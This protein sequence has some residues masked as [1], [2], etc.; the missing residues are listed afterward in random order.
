MK[1]EQRE[2]QTDKILTH[3]TLANVRH[4]SWNRAMLEL[5]LAIKQLKE[6][7]KKYEIKPVG[8][9]QTNGTLTK[10]EE[11][12]REMQQQAIAWITQVGFTPSKHYA[13]TILVEEIS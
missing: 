5:E 2:C 11:R 3:A 13:I 10:L 7:N 1:I 12:E 4:I 8:K 9:D 6:I